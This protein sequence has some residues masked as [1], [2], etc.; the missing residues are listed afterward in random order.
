MARF[1][2]Q[3]YNRVGYVPDQQ[4]QELQDLDAA[5]REAIGSIRS[6]I[7]E[8]AK[9]GLVDM[10]GR[11]EVRNEAGELLEVIRFADAVEVRLEGG[12]SD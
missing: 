7:G 10:Q 3:L 11:I 1:Y 6:M 12:G 9:Q 5:R 2:F 4:G 8:D